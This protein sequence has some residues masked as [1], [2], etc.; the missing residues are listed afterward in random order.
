MIAVM[1]APAIRT[2]PGAGGGG[3]GI[4]FQSDWSTA[5]GTSDA[6]LLDTGKAVPWSIKVTGGGNNQVAAAPG[7][8]PFTNALKVEHKPVPGNPGFAWV[9]CEN[10]WAAPSVG[11]S[12]YLRHYFYNDI[13]DSEGTVGQNSNH[14]LET[15]LEGI[16]AA[17][18]S[19]NFAWT[20]NGTWPIKLF[21]SNGSPNN[22]WT[23]QSSAGVEVQFTKSVWY[24][25]E[26]Q[27]QK[28][29]GTDNWGFDGRIYNQDN[30]Q[31]SGAWRMEDSP[32]T[33][34]AGQTINVPDMD[35]YCRYWR[36]GINGGSD[37]SASRYH[38][39][40][41]VMVRSDTWCGAY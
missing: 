26:F 13:P 3:S 11:N 22:R 2:A 23:F 37:V 25:F 16:G 32:Y 18:V 21:T 24:R 40:G 8:A 31:V 17:G 9:E 12:L 14:P 7:T 38:Y 39:I 27:W 29:S 30:S 20:N 33:A 28:L 15:R 41:G 1:Q 10:V 19:F 6:A 5:T 35:T 4:L 34:M 36:A